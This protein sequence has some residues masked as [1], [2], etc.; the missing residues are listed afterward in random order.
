MSKSTKH[1][2]LKS[3]GA[4][5]AGIVAIIILSSVTDTIL[6]KTG[7]FS[8]PSE[9]FFTLWMILL[10]IVYRTFYTVVGGYIVA[11]LAPAQPMRHAIILGGI[12][13]AI[14]ILTAIATI[15]QNLAPAWFP[16][17]LAILAL[18]A[19]WLGGKLFTRK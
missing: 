15:P 16:I 6:E 1:S 4:V 2:T 17:T 12:G 11:K 13:T 7:I 10:A 18:P 3:V 9:G 5:L 14:G 19:A 8:P